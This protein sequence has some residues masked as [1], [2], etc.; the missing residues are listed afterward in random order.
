MYASHTHPFFLCLIAGDLLGMLLAWSSL[1]P[2]FI[3]VGFVTLIL[4]HRDLHTVESAGDPL[5][6]VFLVHTAEW[7]H[8]VQLII[9]LAPGDPLPN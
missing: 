7:R 6:N 5:P 8:L 2:I 1:L 3:L 4:F 9:A